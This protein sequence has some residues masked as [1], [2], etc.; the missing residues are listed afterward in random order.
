VCALLSTLDVVFDNYVMRWRALASLLYLVTVFGCLN[1]VIPALL[2]SVPVFWTLLS[3]AGLSAVVFLSL[4]FRFRF[5]ASRPGV[6]LM[7]VVMA[8]AMAGAYAGRRAIPP[9]PYYLRTAVAGVVTLADGRVLD[10]PGPV[11]ALELPNVVV[12][13]DVALPA[14]GDEPFQHVW[15]REGL[16]VARVAPQHARLEGKAPAIRLRSQLP[17]DKLP[18][19]RLGEWVVDV[20][21]AGGQLVGR[22]DFAVRR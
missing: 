22:A 1:L 18:A 8:V 9:V 16:E 12:V 7:V 5:L 2:P 20:E 6:V 3:A 15:R 19:E 11:P 13:T 10:A 4:H 17:A 21:T 14:G